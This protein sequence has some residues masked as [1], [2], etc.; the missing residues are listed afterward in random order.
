VSGL[1]NVKTYHAAG[2]HPHGGVYHDRA[3]CPTG[4]LIHSEDLSRG[5][6]GLP[7]CKQCRALHDQD[8]EPGDG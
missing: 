6:K 4:R 2:A 8:S 7:L 3:D 1:K 5:S